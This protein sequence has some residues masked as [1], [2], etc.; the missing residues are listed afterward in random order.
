V[1]D[2]IKL[3]T[4]KNLTNL[5][6]AFLI[7]ILIGCHTKVQT[8]QEILS[9]YPENP[10]YFLFQGKPTVLL[11]SGEHYG[12]VMNTAFDYEKY[13]NTLK[14]EGFNYTRIF[15][16]PYSEIGG[17][18]FGISNNTMN[19]APE[20]WL[21]PWPKE[22]AS[23]KYDLSQWN[24]AFFARL[25]TFVAAASANEIVVE[26]TLFTSYYTNHQWSNSPF[27]PNNNIQ[28]FDSISFKQVNTIN[29]GQLMQ[30]QENYVRKVIQE[31]NRF[32]NVFFEIQN[33]PWADNGQL[34]EKIAETDTLSHPAPWQRIVETAKTESL[35]WQKRIAQIVVDEE[36]QLPNKHLI[37]QNIS[38]FRNQIANPDPNISIFNFHYAYP[39]AA[40]Q[41]L[42]L[43]KAIGLDETGFM[44]QTDFYYRSQAWKFMLAGGALYNNLDYSFTVGSEDGTFAIDSGTPGWGGVAYRKQL[45][46][47]K[48]FIEGFDFWLMK[49]DNSI[50][51]LSQGNVS[52]FQVLAE[53]GK[54][55]A[56]YLEKACGASIQLN[57]PDGEYQMEWLNPV[58][59][60]AEKAVNVTATRG[61]LE[62][63]YPDWS[64][65][66]A[67]KLV[68]ISK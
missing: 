6:F 48:K 64:E 18:N 46:T 24:D 34:A 43:K 32:G 61:R 51:Q 41:N 44:P 21:V 23:G 7:F 5:L 11:T 65:D 54:Q 9:L 36:S 27:N 62:L 63:I 67:L 57:I 25:K 29:N 15:I 28:G 42:G 66:A 8:K 45:Q 59:G 40:T 52:K 31:L 38:N 53:P 47:L 12:A 58:T 1:K 68:L 3:P 2:Q 17:N 35:E 60:I 33:E 14:T 55:Y 30:I 49:P 4:M 39:E 22:S 19:P 37:A 50:L 16:G 10:N 26:V 56:I 13:L 20:N